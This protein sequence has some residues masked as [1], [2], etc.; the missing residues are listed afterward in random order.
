MVFHR[1]HDHLVPRPHAR[2]PEGPRDQ[3]DS[4]G[5]AAH[6]H[7]LARLAGVQESLDLGARALVRRRRSLGKRV[8]PAMN[9]GAIGAA[10]ASDR[11]NH[12]FGHLGGRRVVEVHEPVAMDL[13]P[14][15]REVRP[16]ARRLVLHRSE[17]T[18]GAPC[19]VDSDRNYRE[20]AASGR[21]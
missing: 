11:L 17:R 13:L 4:L 7:D 8:N 15:G 2:V 5:R 12:R 9:V 3:I 6:E 14:Q 21:W 20:Y 19:R 10:E 18:T 16:R 1:R